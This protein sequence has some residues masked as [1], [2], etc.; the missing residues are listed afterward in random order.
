LHLYRRLSKMESRS[1]V[2]SLREELRDRYGALPEEVERLL[3]GHVL[4]LLA[5]ALGIERI[6]VRDREGRLSFRASANPRMTA[7]EGPFR[8]QQ[9]GV[10]VKRLMPLALA[11]RQGGPEPLTRTLIRALE[12]WLEAAL[13]EAA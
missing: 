8:G 4:R 11:L 3:D 7:L 6:I 9:I 12:R 1:D 5:G 2:E 13:R 10:E